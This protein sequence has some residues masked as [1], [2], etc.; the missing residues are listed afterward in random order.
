M[1]WITNIGYSR[2]AAGLY[3][4]PVQQDAANL[5]NIDMHPD[6]D[7]ILPDADSFEEG[8]MSERDP[9]IDDRD[10]LGIVPATF[11]H[12]RRRPHLILEIA[13]VVIVGY[14]AMTLMT[15]AY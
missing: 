4:E 2:G 3:L 12:L 6:A 7:L 14:V 8:E 5:D 13:C 9:V 11:A 10:A 1:T 15:V